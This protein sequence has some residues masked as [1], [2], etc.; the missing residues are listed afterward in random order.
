MHNVPIS[1]IS[2]RW[3]LVP[4]RHMALMSVYGIRKSI[5]DSIF[6]NVKEDMSRYSSNT[7]HSR[8]AA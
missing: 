7:I 8:R 4:L 1:P 2:L 5:G 3:I 6:A